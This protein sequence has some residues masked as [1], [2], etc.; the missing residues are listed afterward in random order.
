MAKTKEK[1]KNFKV[2]IWE[3]EFGMRP[4]GVE[5]FETIQ[6]AKD[7]VQWFNSPENPQ[8]KG[9]DGQYWSA[10]LSI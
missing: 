4:D 1:A 3:H 10:E 7:F 9:G 5:W 6:E 8:R 2:Q